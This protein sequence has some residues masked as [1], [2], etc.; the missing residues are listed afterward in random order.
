MAGLK[1]VLVSF[2]PEDFVS[3][4]PNFKFSKCAVVGM[5][6]AVK[7]TIF[8]HIKTGKKYGSLFVVETIFAIGI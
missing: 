6:R 7:Q 4:K 2:G 5:G 1:L 3:I 8:L